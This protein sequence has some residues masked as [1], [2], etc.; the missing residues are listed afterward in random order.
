MAWFAVLAVQKPTEVNALTVTDDGARICCISDMHDTREA[1]LF[2][3][4]V[5]NFS[6]GTVKVSHHENT[7]T[8]EKQFKYK[9]PVKE[10]LRIEHSVKN[11]IFCIE[12]SGGYYHDLTELRRLNI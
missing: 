8:L 6:P 11:Y 9:L 3:T 4:D 7:K 2:E 1:F 5:I 10:N 12:L